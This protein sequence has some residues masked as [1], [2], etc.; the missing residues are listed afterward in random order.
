MGL[1]PRENAV[2]AYGYGL[3]GTAYPVKRTRAKLIR[4]PLPPADRPADSLELFYQDDAAFRPNP[5][6]VRD[7]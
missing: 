4:Q 6:S 7:F 5:D 2:N 3:T 1:S